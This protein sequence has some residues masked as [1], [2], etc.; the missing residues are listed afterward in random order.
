LEEE[1]VEVLEDFLDG[2]LSN[3]VALAGA[4]VTLLLFSLDFDCWDE[5]NK[6]DDRLTFWMLL[7]S[8]KTRELKIQSEYVSLMKENE[9]IKIAHKIWSNHELFVNKSKKVY[10]WFVAEPTLSAPGA[11]LPPPAADMS[12]VTYWML[13]VLFWLDG[14]NTFN[15][16]ELLS[17]KPYN[18]EITLLLKVSN[19]TSYTNF[20]S[21]N[22]Q[23]L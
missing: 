22:Y 4:A 8:E 6:R 15:F 1:V 17:V 16:I 12:G 11:P 20:N 23:S 19:F 5:T 3:L 9:N 18:R 21:I 13:L 14:V 2:D 10:L 7:L